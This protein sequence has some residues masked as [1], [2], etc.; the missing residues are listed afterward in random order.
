MH[1]A[2]ANSLPGCSPR[3]LF[4]YRTTKLAPVD[5]A[6]VELPP[7]SA[8]PDGLVSVILP[9]PHGSGG[10]VGWDTEHSNERS[11]EPE[12][13][14]SQRIKILRKTFR[15]PWAA[16]QP[17]GFG[18][19][20]ADGPRRRSTEVKQPRRGRTTTP[21]AANKARAQRFSQL[22]VPWTSVRRRSDPPDGPRRACLKGDRSDLD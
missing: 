6:G 8:A 21:W 2:A 13:G 22:N 9:R 15:N 20:G 5:D 1:T 14:R 16:R 10:G 11:T 7:W 3:K 19:H 18:R 17:R 4:T 12:F